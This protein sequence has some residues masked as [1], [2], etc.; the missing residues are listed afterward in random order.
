MPAG[1]RQVVIGIV[2][3]GDKFLNL[4]ELTKDRVKWETVGIDDIGK[5]YK[6]FR[7]VIRENKVF[8]Y[9]YLN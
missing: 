7:L 9:S 8:D 6:E 3:L 1:Y 5:N 2:E 4:Y